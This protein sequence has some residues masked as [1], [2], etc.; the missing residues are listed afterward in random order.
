[1]NL[2]DLSDIGHFNLIVSVFPTLLVCGLILSASF[3]MIVLAIVLARGFYV[4]VAIRN[5]AAADTNNGASTQVEYLALLEVA[6]IL[7]D[8]L[9]DSWANGDSRPITEDRL[10][11]ARAALQRARRNAK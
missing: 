9:E 3:L 6:S 8:I 4:Q 11:H 10:D 2:S 1:M 7:E 5:D